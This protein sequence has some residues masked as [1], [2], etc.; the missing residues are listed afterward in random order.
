MHAVIWFLF[1][2]PAGAHAFHGQLD[3]RKRAIDGGGE[4]MYYTGS[5]RWRGWDCT[6]CHIEPEGRMQMRI[7]SNPPELI[8]EGTYVPDATYS[9]TVRMV[10]EHRGLGAPLNSNTFVLET[11]DANQGTAGFF[12]GLGPNVER[13]ASEEIVVAR[14]E[15][16]RETTWSFEWIAPPPGSG[17][18]TMWLAGVDGDGAEGRLGRTTDPLG[19][20]VYVA[21]LALSESGATPPQSSAAIG[22]MTCSASPHTSALPL[23]AIL[24]VLARRRR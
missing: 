10:G 24:V 2:I 6:T 7:D 12:V 11:L 1:A 21:S 8:G 16:E 17:T 15:N 22:G 3:F 14:G 18:L 19:D 13:P 23:L 9:M 20:D 5:P 4:S